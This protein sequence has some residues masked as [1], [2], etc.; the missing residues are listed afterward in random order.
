MKIAVL[1]ANGQLG[2]D[3]CLVYEGAGHEVARI[4]HD[5][6][7]VRDPEKIE[8][9]LE[10]AAPEIL[11]N[12]AAMHQLDAC[13]ENPEEAFAV[14][15][16]GSRTLARLSKDLGFTLL[17]VSTDYVFDG[18]SSSPYVESDL[19]L[20][21]NVYG[22]SKLAGE[23]F[24]RAGTERHI[25]IRVSALFGNFPCRAKGGR[26]FIQLM[27]KLAQERD[28]VRVVTDEV[29][30]PTWTMDIA[31]QMEV[32]T[33]ARRYGLYHV[34]SQGECSWYDL[35]EAVFEMTGTEVRLSVA[36]QDEF[37]AKVPRP[38]Y[39]VLENRALQEAGCDRMPHWKVGLRNYLAGCGYAVAAGR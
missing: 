26:N 27:L 16:L 24:V 11:I 30:S 20:P 15:A 23:H 4:N 22:N 34:A 39:S 32:L 3:V 36:R 9:A 31:R 2:S 1:G 6:A 14:N 10:K 21:L 8:A 17:H 33:T 5:Q 38:S 13:E 37:P 25:V 35:A 19:P 18:T 28:E 12:T 7:D 29:V